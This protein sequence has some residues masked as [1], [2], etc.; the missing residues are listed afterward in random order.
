[1]N[2]NKFPDICRGTSLEFKFEPIK[3]KNEKFQITSKKS[4]K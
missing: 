2:K 1:M 4:F 3:I